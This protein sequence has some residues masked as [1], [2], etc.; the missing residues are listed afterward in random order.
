M[1]SK[2]LHRGRVR[3]V[4][5]FAALLL[6]GAP[7]AAQTCLDNGTPFPTTAAPTGDAPISVVAC[8]LD[9]DGFPDL[10]TAND[11]TDTVTVLLREANAYVSSTRWPVG[12]AGTRY[13]PVDIACCDLNGDQQLDLITAN[14]SSDNITILYN[15]G[16]VGGV[17]QFAAPVHHPVGE[18]PWAVVC[19][20]ISV[21]PHPDIVIANFSSNTVSVLLNDDAGAIDTLASYTVNTGTAPRT[22]AACDIDGDSDLDV[23]V[24][25][26][27]G[28]SVSV[29]RNDG[30]AGL[31]AAA[32]L[33][34]NVN[35]FGIACCDIDGVHGPD[36]VTA[37]I[38]DD[39]IV[40][41]FN[42][43]AGVFSNRTRLG[44]SDGANNVACADLDHD[45]LLEIVTANISANNISVYPN[46]GGVPGAPL[47]LATALNP[48]DVIVGPFLSSGP[49]LAV[50]SAEGLRI[51]QNQCAAGCQ[52]DLDC[53]DD[54]LFCN[55]QEY[56]DPTA[57]CMSTGTPCSGAASFCWEDS[58]SCGLPGD[59]DRDGDLDL[60]DFSAFTRC[61]GQSLPQPAC[62]PAELDGAAPVDAADFLLFLA[63]FLGPATPP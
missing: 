23:L 62:A 54:G 37:N 12:T 58:G 5:V 25:N 49:D 57:G 7:S 31:T 53:P 2:P 44:G 39:S 8:D 46:V 50:A 35:P 3:A 26:L 1:T 14:R 45:G 13:E 29:L 38:V 51:F 42:N 4:A 59:F 10:A 28:K 41:L 22:L 17:P 20:P 6:S 27:G 61:F 47:Y 56:C 55:G 19:A 32:T 21:D 34:L 63:A 52:V 30:A 9:G 24:G 15:T 48:T 60:H 43:G 16:N 11:A 40:L 33:P 18:A 36:I